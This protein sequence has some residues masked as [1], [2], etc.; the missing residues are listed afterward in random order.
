MEYNGVY[1]VICVVFITCI[2]HLDSINTEQLEASDSK[3]HTINNHNVLNDTSNIKN[4]P[5]HTTDNVYVN[6]TVTNMTNCENTK[7]EM[8]NLL[9]NKGMMMRTLYVIV[10]ITAIIIVYFGIKTIR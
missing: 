4:K 7:F 9:E 2:R 1:L 8:K 3:S 5:Q 10:G 6:C